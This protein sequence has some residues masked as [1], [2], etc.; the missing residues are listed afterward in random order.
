MKSRVGMVVYAHVKLFL[1]MAMQLFLFMAI[2]FHGYA[3]I[4]N[5]LALII[6]L[7]VVGGVLW[8]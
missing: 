6:V 3:L 5:G 2:S 1:F 7:F 4:F 8:V